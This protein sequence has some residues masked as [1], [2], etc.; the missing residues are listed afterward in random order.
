MYFPGDQLFIIIDGKA[1]P[2]TVL[3][4]DCR[5]SLVAFRHRGHAIVENQYLFPGNNATAHS[6]SQ[7]ASHKAS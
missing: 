3:K 6:A 5:Q 2:V 1:K 7:K 4:S